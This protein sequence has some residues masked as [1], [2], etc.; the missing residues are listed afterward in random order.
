LFRLPEKFAVRIKRFFDFKK[1]TILVIILS[2]LLGYASPK[3]YSPFFLLGW[4]FHLW[5]MILLINVNLGIISYLVVIMLYLASVSFLILAIAIF[6]EPLFEIPIAYN[7]FV[8]G[9]MVS[10]WTKE[11]SLFQF[12]F[13]FMNFMDILTSTLGL[14]FGLKINSPNRIIDREKEGEL[15]PKEQILG[16]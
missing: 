10:V 7:S 13:L 1:T 2:G 9:A 16:E 5:P 6:W 12:S 3:V 11:A 4:M 8:S 14:Y 15:I